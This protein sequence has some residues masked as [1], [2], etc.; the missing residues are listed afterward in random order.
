MTK[1]ILLIE[2]EPGL[3]MTIQDRL[4]GEGYIPE[5]ATDGT[6]ALAILQRGE[7]HVVLIILD[8]MLPDID[9]F[10]VCR[11]IRALGNSQPILM[12]TARG[13]VEDRVRGLK[14]GAD[15]YLVKPFSFIE[16]MARI[17]ALL[18]RVH[19]NPRLPE[20]AED[21]EIR[22]LRFGDWLLDTHAH[23]LQSTAIPGLHY[24][25]SAT[26]FRLLHHLVN[27]SG[28]I[29]SRDELLDAVWGYNNEVS[30]RTVD[31][32]IAWLRR[33][34]QEADMPRHIHTVRRSGYRFDS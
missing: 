32:H 27:N 29:F 17:E 14:S 21:I 2:D 8:I 4:R 30:S 28:R 31:V 9:G 6:T 5:L 3:I 10:E 18:R 34:L 26:E 15:D 11:R 12:L 24:Q 33:K 20:K 23:E 1:R 16:L 25:L 19:N 22:Q 13:A 7:P